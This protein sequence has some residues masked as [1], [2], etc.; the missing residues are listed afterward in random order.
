MKKQ[1]STKIKSM[2]RRE[3][4][5]FLGAAGTFGILGMNEH[6]IDTAKKV[7]T[8][9]KTNPD[10][11]KT[12]GILGGLGPQATMDLELRIHR[13]AQKIIPPAQNSG[14]PPMVVQYYRHPPIVLK[15]DHTP[16]FPWQADPRLLDTAKK[17][18]EQADFILI[19]S[20]GVH[21]LQKEIEA[22]SGC[23][24]ISIIDTTL[25]EVKRKGWK[26]IGVLGMM[27]AK[28]YTSRLDELG[29]PFET[30]DNTLQE[31]LNQVIF[32]VMEGTEDE[33]DR[34]IVIEAV[35]Q[36]RSKKA[37]G[38]IPGCTELPIILGKEAEAADMVNPAQLLAEAAV[39]YSIP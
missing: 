35:N 2:S 14:Y 17:L 27:N 3:V 38:I 25:E 28:V 31:K 30:I 39:R 8:I 32:R 10:S 36:L 29:I 22:S 21:L 11:M 20:N 9:K 5:S 16:V 34:A 18:G 15:D 13:V 26:K 19:P 12:I 23:K 37:D 1:E 4:L 24:V 6:T 33:K 7:S